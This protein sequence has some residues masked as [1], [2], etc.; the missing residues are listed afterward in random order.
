MRPDNTQPLGCF[1][2]TIPPPQVFPDGSTGVQEARVTIH[3][4]EGR[5]NHVHKRKQSAAS[6]GSYP[7][8]LSEN[9]RDNQMNESFV[10]AWDKC[11]M[12]Q[13]SSMEQ[14]PELNQP[15]EISEI[16]EYKKQLQN[17]VNKEILNFLNTVVKN[18]KRIIE[19]HQRAQK[20]QS[21]FNQTVTTTLQKHGIILKQIIAMQ[22]RHDGGHERTA[23]DQEMTVTLL[24][25]LLGIFK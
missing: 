12:N 4:S 2:K 16:A 10:Q 20:E 21:R 9:D 19:D 11:D 8:H 14:E 5:F 7:A 13:V 15:P 3:I 22:K 24:N 17:D 1:G 25:E 23:R 18:Q 6:S